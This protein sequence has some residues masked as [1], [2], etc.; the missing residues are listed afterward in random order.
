MN[1]NNAPTWCLL[2]EAETAA[3]ANLSFSSLRSKPSLRRK[4]IL[5]GGA[6][7]TRR[8]PTRLPPEEKLNTLRT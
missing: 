3:I 6:P 5:R 7:R 8:L 1:Y 2:S 4:T